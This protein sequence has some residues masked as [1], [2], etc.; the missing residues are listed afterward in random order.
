MSHITRVPPSR[1]ILQANKPILPVPIVPKFPAE[2]KGIWRFDEV[3]DD[4]VGTNDF[5]PNTGAAVYTLF[6]RYE[7]IPNSLVT[8]NGLTFEED[9]I[10][11]AS[12]SY[13]YSDSWTISFWWRSP[14]LV[15]FTRHVN[16]RELESKVAPLFAIGNSQKTAS[17][18]NI[19]NAS[20]ILTE[21]GDSKTK[22]AVRAYVITG[23]NTVSH[24]I[25]SKPYSAPGLHH[26][27]VTYI[28]TQQRFRIDIDGE[29][30]ILH[31]APGAN[32]Q[33]TGKLRINDIV[34]GFLAHK[35]TQTGGYMFDLL[36]TTYASTDNE[37]LKMFRYGYEHI[38]EET[39]FDAR[40]AYFGLA[41]SQP[42]TV[43]TSHIFVDGGNIFAARSDGRI[44]K[45]ARPVWDK[46]A[47]YPN[48]QSVALLNTSKTDD[49]NRTIEWT[50]GG[51][52]LKGVSVTI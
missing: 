38:T 16:T 44:V 29:T 33:R 6:S 24:V 37:S 48:T 30:G 12:N 19:S 34:P 10:Y 14:G 50:T 52:K 8:R 51:L 39:L 3:L 36:F 32:L 47:N 23:G 17:K 46:E 9:K 22:N 7:L 49:E 5:V 13:A 18:T 11:T 45:G 41:Y 15:G 42:S 2:V 21:I 43:S 31:S 1:T 25:T 40:F 26:I 20:V 4:V 27:L 28:R 35:T